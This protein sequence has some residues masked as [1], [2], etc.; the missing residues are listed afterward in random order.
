[1]YNVSKGEASVE[2][3]V[4]SAGS[5][6]TVGGGG[7]RPGIRTSSFR[8][9]RSRRISTKDTPPKSPKP[10]QPENKPPSHDDTQSYFRPP[11]KE[12]LLATATSFFH[13]LHIRIKWPLIRSYRPFNMDDI[14]AFISVYLLSHAFLLIAGTTTFFLLIIATINTV[15][16]QEYFARVVG[17][18]LTRESGMTVVFESAIVPKWQ[19]KTVRFERVF[20][21]RRPREG[22]V[23]KGSSVTAAAVAASKA[24]SQPDGDD[25][26][27]TQFDLT[28]ESVDVTLSF[29]K[30]VNGKGLLENVEMR[31]VRGV[32]DRTHIQWTPFDDPLTWRHK[33]QPGDFELNSFK[34]EDL[35]VTVYQPSDFRPFTV[36]IYSC[37]LPKLRKHWFF[38]DFLCANTMSGTYDNSLFTI[39]PRQTPSGATHE[40]GKISRL[41][42]DGVNVDHLN[43]GVG[44]GM[45]SWVVEGKVDVIAD[46]QLPVNIE[47]LDLRK[48]V[49]GVRENIETLTTTTTNNGHE[50]DDEETLYAP[51]PSR[52][53]DDD[54]E[55]V[56]F[57]IIVSLNDVRAQVPYLT[58]DLSYVNNALIRPIVA[59]INSR[60]THIP[61]RCQVVLPLDDFEGSWGMWECG[62][63]DAV[64]AE[65]PPLIVVS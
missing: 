45:F 39:H 12:Q 8:A 36:S 10:D 64:S 4:S 25:G 22:G 52:V 47:E 24:A 19:N 53:R 38:Y 23:R 46:M 48:I 2:K 5:A 51:T 50:K 15:G 21:S 59:Y 34:L 32:V 37:D 3:N 17:A 57:D 27:Y 6:A 58:P 26:N 14:S 9:A 28:I 62:L 44:A 60:R 56:V 31:G 7:V 55:E 33:H 30:W 35:L 49:E 65:V 18:Y 16:A 1:V 20:V 11:T 61:V 40:R 63:L 29:V 41:R 54:T 13:R 43:R 42:I